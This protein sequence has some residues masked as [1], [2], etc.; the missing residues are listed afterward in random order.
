MQ[1]PRPSGLKPLG[2]TT[3]R[4]RRWWNHGDLPFRAAI[5]LAGILVL[6]IVLAIGREL[7]AHSILPRGKFGLAFLTTS[8]WDPV[9]Q[10]FGAL[11]FIIGT[12]ETSVLALLMAIPAGIGVAIF[13]AELAPD[14]LRSP[15]GTLIELLAAV[16]SVVF[17]LWGLFVFIPDIVKPLGDTLHSAFSFVPL[18][19][20]PVYGPSRLAASMILA[21]MILPTITAVTRDVFLALPRT[22]SEAA[23][24]LGATRWEMIARVLV[25]QSL[26]GILGA[27]I[28]GL[29]RALGET[30][31][32][33]MVIGNNPDLSASLLHPGY[34]MASLIANEFSEAT[35]EMYV[36]ALI[37]IGLVLFVITLLL[38]MIARLLV[39]RVARRF[40]GGT[41]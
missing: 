16:P 37:E 5:A 4:F 12:I 6:V 21:I 33:T 31:A 9:R 15:L 30:I 39:W 19:D 35:N 14:W 27:V 32:V 2:S 41:A 13:L 28:L 23:F 25:P 20:G 40:A 1:S 7:W 10:E 3:G 18:F 29:G 22:Q 8:T 36:Q 17:G 38:N 24:A 11:P 26:S 34:T